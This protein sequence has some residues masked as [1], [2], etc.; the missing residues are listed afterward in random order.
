MSRVKRNQILVDSADPAYLESLLQLAASAGLD[1]VGVCDA[2]VLDRARLAIDDRNERGLS[3]T[4]SF[5]FR[6]PSRSTDPDRSVSGARSIIVG[7]RS[8][9]SEQPD[10]PGDHYAAPDHAAA[11]RVHH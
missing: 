8:Y 11:R 10:H 6:H 2:S 5:T 4:M 9:Y 1:R 7:A 3:D